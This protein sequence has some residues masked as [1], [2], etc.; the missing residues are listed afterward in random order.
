MVDQIKVHCT[1]ND[2][3]VDAKVVDHSDGWIT[4][5][6][7]PGDVKVIM[8]KTK[9]KQYVGTMSGYEFVYKED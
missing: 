4:V 7:Q 6:L 5:L 1:D 2:K 8:K 9:P 3:W